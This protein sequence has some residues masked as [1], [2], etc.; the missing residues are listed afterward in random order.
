VTITLEWEGFAAY[1]NPTAGGG[2]IN[3]NSGGFRAEKGVVL[4]KEK[5]CT[6][7]NATHEPPTG[8]GG[9]WV[10]RTSITSASAKEPFAEFQ[11][12]FVWQDSCGRLQRTSAERSA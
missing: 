9:H 12:K 11:G 5:V 2:T 1:L 8:S 6:L 7:K 4:L 10:T 3:S